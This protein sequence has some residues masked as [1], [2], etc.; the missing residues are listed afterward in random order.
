[1]IN[2]LSYLSGIQGTIGQVRTDANAD[3]DADANA[4][5]DVA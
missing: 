3:A 2:Y 5:A 1:M 4:D